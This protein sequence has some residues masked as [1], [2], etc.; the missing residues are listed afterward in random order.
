MNKKMSIK[1]KIFELSYELYTSLNDENEEY[2]L[3]LIDVIERECLIDNEYLFTIYER[4][5]EWKQ[6][7]DKSVTLFAEELNDYLNDFRL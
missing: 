2:M 6:K 5:S 1:S 3:V 7:K 4:I